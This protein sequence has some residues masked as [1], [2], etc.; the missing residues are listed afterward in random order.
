M[1][2]VTPIR[3]AAFDITP[4]ADGYTG[5]AIRLSWRRGVAVARADDPRSPV[6]WVLVPVSLLNRLAAASYEYGERALAEEALALVREAPMAGLGAN[7]SCSL[8]GAPPDPGS[9]ICGDCIARG[10]PA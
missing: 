1:G 5:P 6:P 9:D 7:G 8:C 10:N 3:T 4:P 2:T